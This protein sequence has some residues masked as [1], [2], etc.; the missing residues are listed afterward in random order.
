MP[1]VLKVSLGQPSEINN[2]AVVADAVMIDIPPGSPPVN[3]LGSEQGKLGEI[4]L[5]TTHPQ[6]P[7]L[8]ILVRFAVEG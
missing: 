2:G 3:H 8:R 5:E 1:S 7:K 4:I 6:V